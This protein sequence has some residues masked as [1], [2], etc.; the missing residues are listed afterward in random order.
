[1][2]YGNQ[3][4]LNDLKQTQEDN[5]YALLFNK[6]IHIEQN[7][8]FIFMDLSKN[9]SNEMLLNGRLETFHILINTN[10][11]N[12]INL[13]LNTNIESFCKERKQ[14]RSDLVHPNLPPT[15]KY[16]SEYKHKQ[17]P[18]QSPTPTP[19]QSNQQSVPADDETQ[20]KI[21]FVLKPSQIVLFEN[22]EN[23]DSNRLIFNLSLDLH[24]VQQNSERKI[25][26]S[27]K[28]L[29]FYRSNYK[30]FKD[31]KIKYSVRFT[32]SKSSQSNLFLL[33]EDHRPNG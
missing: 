30:Q 9:L 7:S 20:L 10:L 19:I 27:I 25:A 16:I 33:I 6:H 22:G 21:D 28:H 14:Q 11:I 24:L 17:I 2:N 8:P 32:L 4:L 1:M 26:A 15:A 5:P 18:T 29:S 12:S 13:F 31:S 23:K 3:N